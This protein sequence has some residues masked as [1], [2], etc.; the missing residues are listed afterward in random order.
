MLGTKRRRACLTAGRR[1][2]G[3][4]CFCSGGLRA[5]VGG[6]GNV[7]LGCGEPAAH[8]PSPV[9]FHPS[10]PPAP[11]APPPFDPH[12]RCPPTL[13][14]CAAPVQ[15]PL[16][17]APPCH[18]A[19]ASRYRRGGRLP[20]GWPYRP[21]LSAHPRRLRRRFHVDTSLR[22]SP[23]GPCFRQPPPPHRTCAARPRSHPHPRRA[24]PPLWRR[25]F[26]LTGGCTGGGHCGGGAG[27]QLPVAGQGAWTGGG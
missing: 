21:A 25:H 4:G 18:P 23:C 27:R 13:A 14:P 22:A 10:T 17:A 24:T 19:G 11:F 1:G 2:W 8:H 7:K 6:R 15:I 3:W 12:P 26:L 9:P 5:R 20:F 16:G